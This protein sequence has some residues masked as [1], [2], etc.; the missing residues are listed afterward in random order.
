ML[1]VSDDD[2]L[3]LS[4]NDKNKAFELAFNQYWQPLFRQ[5]YK[6]IQSEEM[7]KDLVQEVFIAL[8]DNF[9]KIDDRMQL[10]PYLYGILRNKVLQHYE[11]NE[12]RLRYAM[13]VAANP[14]VSSPSAYNLLLGKELQYII[15]DE[16]EKMP[17]R[18]REIY[19]LKKDDQLSAREIAEKLS[20]S[21]QTVKNQLLSAANRLRQR[22]GNYNSPLITIYF[23]LSYSTFC[24][25][26]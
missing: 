2:I 1:H 17:D 24:F 26:T 16:I 12:V 11:K 7:A 20:I 8:W 6:K 4:V 14:E 18:M 21:E 19:L 9:G 13:T 15:K 3:S 23:L 5:A 22:I 25:L 10:L